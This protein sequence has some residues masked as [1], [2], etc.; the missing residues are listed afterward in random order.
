MTLFKN[1]ETI[2]AIARIVTVIL[3]VGIVLMLSAEN[4]GKVVTYRYSKPGGCYS[5]PEEACARNMHCRTWER[6]V[7]VVPQP[8]DMTPPG[9]VACKC[10]NQFKPDTYVFVLMCA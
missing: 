2:L 4:T 10:L 3:L 8:K 5:T 7:P 1:R 6:G 9:Y